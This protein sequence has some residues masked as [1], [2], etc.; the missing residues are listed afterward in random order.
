MPDVTGG[1][2]PKVAHGIAYRAVRNRGTIGGSLTHADP[3]ADWIS[4]LAALGASVTLRGPNGARTIPVED[5]MLGAL[6]ADLRPG[7]LL[8]SVTAPRLSQSARWGYYKICRKTGEFAHAIGAFV[9]DPERGDLPRGHRRDRDT[10]DRYRRRSRNYRRRRSPTFRRPGGRHGGAISRHE[11]SAGPPDAC[12]R[13][14]AR[15]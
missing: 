11:G 9:I 13:A 12:R 14:A 1:A 15:R 4:I 7:E 8:I 2:L 6:E 5:Y 10:P 3:S